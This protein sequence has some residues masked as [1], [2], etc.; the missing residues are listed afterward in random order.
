MKKL[1][2]IA[3][4]AL[5]PLCAAIWSNAQDVNDEACQ[6]AIQTSCTK[7]HGAER[8]CNK[9]SATDADWPAIVARMSK[10]AALNQETQD[11]VLN[12]LTKS[13]DPKKIVCNK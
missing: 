2:I 12:C 5:L 6:Q 9:L 1:L 8:I 11:Q 10:K 13:A 7:C 4:L 3:V